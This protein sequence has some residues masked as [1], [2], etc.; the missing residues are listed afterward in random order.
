[1]GLLFIALNGLTQQVAKSLTYKNTFVGFYE[2]KPTNYNPN[3]KYPLIIFL[4]GIGERGNGTTELPYLLW[5]GIPKNIAEGKTMTF[6]VNG[7]TE[8]FL[9]LSPQLP[10]WL[11]AWDNVYVDAML[12]YAKKNLNVDD[13]RV[14]LT[15]LSLGGGGVW[16]YVTSSLENAKKFAAIAPVCGVC[17][18]DLKKVEPTIGKANIGVWGFANMDDN[19][20]SPWCTISAIDEL[21]KN[22][23]KKIKKT[24]NQWGGHD[25]W[26]KAYDVGHSIHSP[27]LYEWFLSEADNDDD[28][29]DDDDDNQSN[30]GQLP[31]NAAPVAKAGNDITITLPN[32][33]VTLSNAGSYDSDGNIK[34]WNWTKIS[35][36]GQPSIVSA[37][38]QSTAVRNLVA[39]T[40][41][42]RLTVTDNQNATAIDDVTVVVNAA[43]NTA[44]VAKAGND[45]SITLPDN[46]VTLSNAGS[47]DS[48]GD[49]K[50]WNWTKI[51]GPSQFSIVAANN[52]STA[53]NNLQ[54][55]TYVFRLTVTDNDNATATDDVTVTVNRAPNAVPVAKAGNDISL[56]LPSNSTTL[57]NSG[58]YDADGNIKSYSWTKI[59]GPSQFTLSNANGASTEVKDLQAGSYTFRLTVT[60]DD[61]ATATD[62]VTINVNRAPNVAPVAKAGNDVNITLPSNSIT[63]NNSGSYDSDGS[64]RGYSWTKVSGPSQFS[65]TNANAA[66]TEVRNLEAGSYTFR[67]TV[68]DDDGA[69]ASDDVTIHVNRAPNVA[70]VAKA[71]NDINITLPTNSITLSNAGS[72]DADGNIK[73]FSWTKISGPSQFTLASPHSASTLVNNLQAGGYIFRLTVTDDEGATASDDVMV[74]VT[75]E[76]VV[77]TKPPVAVVSKD[78]K[79][80]VGQATVL[81]GENS[82]GQGSS[83]KSYV[84]SKYS[85]PASHEILTPYAQN[86]WIRNMEEGVYVYRLTVT[87]YNGVVD[88]D[89]VTITVKG[90]LPVAHAGK[91]ETIPVGQSTV[92]HGENSYVL[93]GVIRS[94]SWTKLSGP[95]AY[96]ITDPNSQTT[97]IRNMTSGTYVYRLTIK[98]NNG[99][100]GVDDVIIT[101]L[102]GSV[103]AH[104]GKDETIPQGQATVLRGDGSYS[105]SGNIKSYQWTK[106]SGPGVYEIMNPENSNSWVTEMVP[107]VYTFRLTVTDNRGSVAYDDVNIIV[108]QSVSVAG[109][110][111][112]ELSGQVL[113]P[114]ETAQ[115]TITATQKL[116]IYPNPVISSLNIRWS[117]EQK[118]NATINIV[119]AGGRIVKTLN[120][121]KENLD[122]NTSM[123]VN[124]LAPGLYTVQILLQNGKPLNKQ[125]LKR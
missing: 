36:P 12:D 48:D 121:K 94:Y 61:G 115:A 38:D 109:R 122:F 87:D 84:W 20:V 97:W 101:V 91:D 21:S 15:G 1:M 111:G 100:E 83:I 106:I 96:E 40:Y 25:A 73:S 88:T 105:T 54:V 76:P 114:L 26:T 71:G 7:K 42:F 98:D 60:D 55:G 75:P 2:Y 79:I 9:V 37:N 63:L 93:G 113:T 31:A 24:I 85:G 117:G 90:S 18:Y 23:S 67:L 59:S 103:I 32:N 68:T 65:I 6:T 107:G 22:K 118:G 28:D 89:D 124:S 74:V 5:Q 39:G 35:G 119:D 110:S 10:K 47:Y 82:Y 33:Q 66:S 81:R 95:A 53:V 19:I 62:D 92:L 52:A 112:N 86:T 99:Y 8:T 45:L 11:G 123:D 16:S 34:G 116:N 30:S 58:S 120:V 14:F 108:G 69:T 4:H 43:R 17:Y 49:I 64:I 50:G 70:P 104:A 29:D 57:S 44:P 77:V 125:F 78:E 27:N 3:K 102:N 51:S 46:N 56:T 13:K 41:V 80:P 72:Y